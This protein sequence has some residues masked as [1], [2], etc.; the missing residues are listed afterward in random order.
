MPVKVKLKCLNICF[1]YKPM[2]IFMSKMISSMGL[3]VAKMTKTNYVKL[4][5]DNFMPFYYKWI[6]KCVLEQ[7]FSLQLFA[8]YY[9]WKRML[10]DLMIQNGFSTFTQTVYL[11]TAQ[12]C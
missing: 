9:W 8:S 11:L 10:L 12:F 3:K 4:K 6:V 5:I 2:C 1:Q 7:M